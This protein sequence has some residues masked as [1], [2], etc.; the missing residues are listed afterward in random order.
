MSIYNFLIMANPIR[1]PKI[2]TLDRVLRFL[3]KQNEP[4]TKTQIYK[5]AHTDYKSLVVILERLLKE[6]KIE[7]IE[8]SNR[9][10]YKSNVLSND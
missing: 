2:V 4:L 7:K 9:I 10:F 3:S 8:I 6:G 5:Q 1:S